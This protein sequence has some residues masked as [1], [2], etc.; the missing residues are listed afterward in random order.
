[1]LRSVVF[2]VLAVLGLAG[3]AM[4]PPV[5]PEAIRVDARRIAVVTAIADEIHLSQLAFLSFG[6]DDRKLP[7]PEWELDAT[8]R[9]AAQRHLSARF[10]DK[11]L[12]FADS[13]FSTAEIAAF[14]ASVSPHKPA[15]GR[16]ADFVRSAGADLAIVVTTYV[17][18]LPSENEALRGWPA[19]YLGLSIQ[20]EG[21]AAN[22][23]PFVALVV[24]TLDGASLQRLARKAGRETV[25]DGGLRYRELNNRLDA[26][27]ERYG[28][29]S[30]LFK[31]DV[32]SPRF[33]RLRE[34]LTRMIGEGV[35]RL[36]TQAGY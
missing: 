29:P 12:I 31:E 33:M 9:A 23:T 20:G 36:L 14:N 17:T 21:E 30:A 34:D 1:M 18:R 15:Q 8:A 28:P 27:R 7:V 6:N 13:D 19:D 16:I 10:P 11:T 24:S 3:C 2:V 4:S 5:I 22:V 26:L 35:P 25:W 32:G